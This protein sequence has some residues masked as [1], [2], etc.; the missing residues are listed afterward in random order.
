MNAYE[1][2]GDFLAGGEESFLLVYLCLFGSILY[3]LW[4]RRDRAN[5]SLK[6]G[7]NA[8]FSVDRLGFILDS[9]AKYPL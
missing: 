1:T 9:T 4:L 3:F 8:Q 6:V 5:V 7:V 2:G